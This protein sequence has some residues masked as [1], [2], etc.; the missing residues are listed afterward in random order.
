M[1]VQMNISACGVVAAAVSGG[2]GVYNSADGD[3][4]SYNASQSEAA[5]D[6]V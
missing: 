2:R 3:I 1:Q 4:G 6:S 5:T